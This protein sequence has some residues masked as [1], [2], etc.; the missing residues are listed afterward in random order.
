MPGKNKG[1]ELWKGC[2]KHF[3]LGNRILVNK[4]VFP[5]VKLGYGN[6]DGTGIERQ[7]TSYQQIAEN[8]PGRDNRKKGGIYEVQTSHFHVLWRMRHRRFGI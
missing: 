6:P 7:L 8:A 3:P 4:F 1:E 5:P 2:M